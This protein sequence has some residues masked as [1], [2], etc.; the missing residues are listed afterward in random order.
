VESLNRHFTLYA[1]AVLA[2]VGI[3]TLGVSVYQTRNEAA[4]IASERQEVAASSTALTYGSWPALA[5]PEFYLQVRQRFIES[6]TSFITADLATMTLGL[7][8]EG[9]LVLEVPITAKPKEGTWGEAP[10]GLYE[11]QGRNEVRYSSFGEV[12]LPWALSFQGNFF[13]HGEP[14]YQGGVAVAQNFEGG[15]IRLTDESARALYEFSQ[16]GMPVLIYNAA[17]ERSSFDYKFKAPDIEATSFAAV[18]L[19][20]GTVLA[21]EKVAVQLPVASVTKLMTALVVLEYFNLEHQ[22]RTPRGAL[23]STT[24][25]RLATG[26]SYSVYDLLHLLLLESSNEAA[27]A[28]AAALGREQFIDLMNKK[29]AAI[30]MTRTSFIDPSGLG[31]GNSSTAE[32]LYALGKYLYDNHRFI[33]KVTN[34]TAQEDGQGVLTFRNIQNFNRVA[35]VQNPFLGGKVG[36][37]LAA[38]ETYLGIFGL[39][40]NGQERPIVVTILGAGAAKTSVAKALQYLV[41]FYELSPGVTTVQ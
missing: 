30:G 37:T 33:L 21:G 12:Y 26:R 28:L 25:P 6:G 7:Y 2:A 15:G 18:D 32:D 23:V 24:V 14:Y 34:N 41:D 9:N 20:D 31:V 3:T 13:I 10:V 38:R 35:G 19:I 17:P 39:E 22:V 1:A 27:E 40:V 4:A 5:N 29:A 8:Q 16:L 36:Q 11:V